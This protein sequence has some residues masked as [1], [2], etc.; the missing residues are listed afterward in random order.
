MDRL[1]AWFWGSNTMLGDACQDPSRCRTVGGSKPR[2]MRGV[3]Q[4]NVLRWAL[5]SAGSANGEREVVAH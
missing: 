3:S 4:R 5:C 1:L 2:R